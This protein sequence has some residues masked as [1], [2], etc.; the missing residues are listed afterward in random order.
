MVVKKP[1]C[2]KRLVNTSFTSCLLLHG[3]A[4]SR[5]SF[6][7]NRHPR[8]HQSTT[9][10]DATVPHNVLD[11]VERVYGL[12]DLH[13]DKADN[14]EWLAEHC[15]KKLSTGD[16]LVVAGDVSH[17][18]DR[19]QHVFETIQSTGARVIYVPGNHEAWISTKDEEEGRN[20]YAKLKKIEQLCRDNG[21]LVDPTLITNDDASL[22]IV[23]LLSWYDASLTIPGCEDLCTDF[24]HWPW[25]DFRACQWTD[26]PP[27]A[28]STNS[29]NTGKVPMGLAQYYHEQNMA[30]IDF[31]KQSLAE[32]DASVMTMSHF[33]PNMQCLP[34]WKDL[35]SDTFLREEW[36]DH[37]GPGTSAKF[38]KVAGSQDLEEQIRSIGSDIH[39]F[40]HSHRPKDFCYKGIRY[41]HNPLGN[42]R[43]RLLYMVSPDVDFQLLWEGGSL[44]EGNQVMRLWEEEGGGT[45]ALQKRLEVHGRR[46]PRGKSRF[47]M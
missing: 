1:H 18:Y 22:W 24:M 46:R 15:H 11:D 32:N 29:I 31:V 17:K 36:M 44:V 16:L 23:P 34:D 7:H 39:V 25:T 4:L 38:A 10:R 26:H 35:S 8:R 2:L 9:T 41:V 3:P 27:A 47:I 42:P 43:E 45:L 37:G 5:S 13:V 40:G 21:V 30:G 28:Q 12:S 19:L 6:V 14:R 33:L 20:S